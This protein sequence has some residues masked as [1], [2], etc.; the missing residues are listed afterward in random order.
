MEYIGIFL[1]LILRLR[2]YMGTDTIIFASNF[3]VTATREIVGGVFS[4]GRVVSSDPQPWLNFG[5]GFTADNR[6][7]FFSGRFSGG[8]IYSEHWDEGRLDFVTAFNTYPHLIEDGQGL[9]LAPFPGVTQTFLDNRVLRAFMGQ[10]AD[11]TF[12]IGNVGGANMREVQDIAAYFDLV[13]AT[14][15]DGGASAGIWRNGTYIT[16]PGRLLPVVTFITGN[17]GQAPLTQTPISVTINGTAVNFTDQQPALIDGRTLVPVRGVF[18]ALDFEV[19]WN[20]EARQVTLSRANDTIVITIDSATFT[21][22]GIGHTLDV[23][24]QIIGGSTMLPIRA[25]LE[26]VGYELDWDGVTQTVIISTD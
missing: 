14:N 24:A 13:N 16:R 20:P 11:G 3:H 1:L 22:N 4:Q 18:E 8:Y 2:D 26:A 6:F 10:R 23:P 15:I 19:G 21:A 7:S 9:P 12:V 17:P 5:A 25:V